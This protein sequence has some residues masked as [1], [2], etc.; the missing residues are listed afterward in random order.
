MAI[1]DQQILKK[2]ILESEQALENGRI[3]EH[4]KAIHALTELLLEKEAPSLSTSI[5]EVEWRKMVGETPKK[6]NEKVDVAK[7]NSDSLLDF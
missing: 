1:T 3:R 4:A 7:E 2:I 5:D 6:T